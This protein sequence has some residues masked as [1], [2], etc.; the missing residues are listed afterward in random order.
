MFSSLQILVKFLLCSLIFL[1]SIPVSSTLLFPP[2]I[3]IF[4]RSFF[5]SISHPKNLYLICLQ[6]S[7]HE[8]PADFPSEKIIH[9]DD[10]WDLIGRNIPEDTSTSLQ[11]KTPIIEDVPVF[12]KGY[13]RAFDVSSKARVRANDATGNPS[14]QLQFYKQLDSYH[15]QDCLYNCDT[16][17]EVAFR[18]ENASCTST[19][20][21][22]PQEEEEGEDAMGICDPSKYLLN[23]SF[24]L[25]SQYKKD[26]QQIFWIYK[27]CVK[28]T[29][30]AILSAVL[31]SSAV[32][33]LNES[34]SHKLLNEYQNC[35]SHNFCGANSDY[36]FDYFHHF[37]SSQD[38]LDS[39]HG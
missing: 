25:Y 1:K 33:P 26:N 18:S 20:K 6:N 30:K 16:A 13:G 12:I 38:P 29:F 39:L 21:I 4:S 7:N 15:D 8:F 34:A 37:Q 3:S 9:L 14:T 31:P 22:C 19:P 2:D 23:G 24:R 11:E 35:F 5:V 28:N 17:L 27:T 36:F 10:F 32:F